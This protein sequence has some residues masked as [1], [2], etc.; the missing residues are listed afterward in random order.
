MR[1][2][3]DQICNLDASRCTDARARLTK[4]EERAKNSCPACST[5]T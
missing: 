2:S 1:R 3:A 4:A 5:P